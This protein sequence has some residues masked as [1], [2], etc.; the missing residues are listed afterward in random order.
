MKNWRRRNGKGRLLGRSL[1][2]MNKR[3]LRGYKKRNKI[4][5]TKLNSSMNIIECLKFKTRKE[6]TSGPKEK[7]E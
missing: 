1:Q 5:S 2:K 3:K 4:K 6:L 7:K